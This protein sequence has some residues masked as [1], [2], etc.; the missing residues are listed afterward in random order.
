MLE[1]STGTGR[2]FE[3]YKPEQVTSATFTDKSESMLSEAKSKFEQ[4]KTKFQ[5]RFEQSNV[6]AQPMQKYDTVVDTFGLCSCGDP[7][8]AL[9][10]LAKACKPTEESRILLLEHGRSHYDWL[11]RILDSN[12][13]KHVMR[14]GCWWNRDLMG[15]FE[16]EKVKQHIEIVKVYRWHLGTTCYIVAKPRT[17][18]KEQEN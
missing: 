1:A 10:S 11:N 12:V 18:H 9:I 5:A 14:W 3:Y 4:Y 15:L 2:N 13:D 16:R 6:D 17:P 8:E 7:E